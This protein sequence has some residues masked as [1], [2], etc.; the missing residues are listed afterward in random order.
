M[1]N[2]MEIVLVE[3]GKVMYLVGSGIVDR[4]SN[5]A[6]FMTNGGER[7]N[8]VSSR[9]K[10]PKGKFMQTPKSPESLLNIYSL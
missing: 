9:E 1:A 6:K 3:Y 10:L 4:S 8:S 2:S 5:V 7:H